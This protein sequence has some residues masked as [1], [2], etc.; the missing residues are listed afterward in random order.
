MGCPPPRVV[1]AGGRA[2]LARSGLLLVAGME[3]HAEDL[4]LAWSPWPR[5]TG[6]TRLC[7][8]GWESAGCP[9]PMRWPGEERMGACLGRRRF[10]SE[11]HLQTALRCQRRCQAVFSAAGPYLLSKPM[12]GK[13]LP[14]KHRGS[15]DL[16]NSALTSVPW[17]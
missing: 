13:S 12:P 16:L 2:P 3:E 1:W 17:V 15:P 9:E 4:E 10:G 11:S 7:R 6:K 14:S 5:R 8:R